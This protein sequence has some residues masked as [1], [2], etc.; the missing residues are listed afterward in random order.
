MEINDVWHTSNVWLCAIVCVCRFVCVFLVLTSCSAL[1]W[2]IWLGKRKVF[3]VGHESRQIYT[4][5]WCGKTKL[6]YV[7]LGVTVFW[8]RCAI[9]KESIWI[10]IFGRKPNYWNVI[11]VTGC[12]KILS[13]MRCMA[14][15]IISTEFYRL[16]L[17]MGFFRFDIL[18]RVKCSF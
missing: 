13:A 6:D 9:E 3:F 12:G 7:T 2:I 10:Y 5:K 4:A 11:N 18:L 16:N 14:S 15:R 1:P 8:G 17:Q